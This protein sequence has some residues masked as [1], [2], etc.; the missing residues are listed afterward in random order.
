MAWTYRLSGWRRAVNWLVRGL[1]T[2][3]LGPPRTYLLSVPGRRSGQLRSTPVTLV[4]EGG[5]RWL[6]APYGAVGWVHNA[7]AA[8]WVILNRGG[9]SERVKIVELGPKESA[10]VLRT[11]IKQVPIVRPFFD[12]A[13][14]STLEAIETEA[15]RHPVFQIL[16]PA[17]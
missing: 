11:Y 6:V 17:P 16:G 2:A 15:S 4:E 3:N 5:R 1:L 9:R 13:P 10:P 7:R 14:A 12:V 8:G